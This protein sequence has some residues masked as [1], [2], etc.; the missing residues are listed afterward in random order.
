[1]G[2]FSKIWNTFA[3]YDLIPKNRSL[4]C[5]IT[6]LTRIIKFDDNGFRVKSENSGVDDRKLLSKPGEALNTEIRKMSTFFSIFYPRLIFT[7]PLTLI[8]TN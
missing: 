5:S 3:D 2:L 1:M 4:E 6:P 7:F 8:A